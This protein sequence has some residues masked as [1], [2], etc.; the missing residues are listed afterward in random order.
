ML[1]RFAVIILIALFLCP[2]AYADISLV[3]SLDSVHV[4]QMLFPTQPDAA[5]KAQQAVII[6][7]GMDK[8]W[9]VIR[10]N[11]NHKLSILTD[12]AKKSTDEFFKDTPINPEAVVIGTAVIV[13]AA[14]Q[15]QYTQSLGDPFNLGIHQTFT[16]SY[17]KV[18]TGITYSF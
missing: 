18:M 11:V 3:P 6:Q 4:G 16:V 17:T 15:K 14:T 7:T 13:T 5:N 9:S 10:K 2:S 12:D 8:D 1:K